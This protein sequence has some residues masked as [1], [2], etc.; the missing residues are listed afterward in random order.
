MGA[1]QFLYVYILYG[2]VFHILV[3]I[4]K[5]N[6]QFIFPNLKFLHSNYT[7]P[8]I[9]TFKYLVSDVNV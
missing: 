6:D 3:Q 5:I 2:Y 8:V 1:I 9:D 4:E 7:E